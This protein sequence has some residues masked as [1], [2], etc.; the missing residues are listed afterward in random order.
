[1]AAAAPGTGSETLRERI[2]ALQASLAANSAALAQTQRQRRKIERQQ[3]QGGLGPVGRQRV[4]S[5]YVLSNY[6]ADLAVRAACQYSTVKDPSSPGYP[7]RT[8]VE[9]LFLAASD[10]DLNFIHE[11][12]RR[13][14]AQWETCRWVSSLNAVGVAPLSRDVFDHY[15]Q[16]AFG[17]T[18]DIGM[19]ARRYVNKWVQR[20][21]SKWGVQRKVK[22]FWKLLAYYAFTKFAGKQILYLNLDETSIPYTMKPLPGCVSLQDRRRRMKVKKQDVRGALTYVSIIC[23]SKDIQGHLPHYLIGSEAKITKK[24]LR[25]QQA[26]PQTA[27]RVLRRKS[28]WTTSADLV[29]IL[30][31]LAT[32]LKSWPALQPVLLLDAAPSHLPKSVMQTAKRCKIQLLFI[33]AACTDKLQPLDLA[34]FSAFKGHLKRKQQV[35]RA[36]S[37]DGLIDPLAWVFDIM[38]CPRHFFAAKSWARS[39]ESVGASNPPRADRLHS[40][41]QRFF[42]DV[43]VMPDGSKPSAAE[44]QSIWPERRRMAYAY[45]ALL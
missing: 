26:L 7:T 6:N 25:A 19:P 8:F 21:R 14:V 40:E 10:A 31:E 2:T 1:M 15:E 39:F 45:R 36:G 30:K 18:L 17:S 32:V 29:L 5:V 9:D 23:D 41:L 34:A 28:A 22:V 37:V 4:L 11:D 16:R 35:L 13:F 44:L 27:L 38:Q 24:F 12:S 20:W 43:I 42:G 3:E 33:P